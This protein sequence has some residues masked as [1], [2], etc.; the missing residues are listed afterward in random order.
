[1]ETWVDGPD[2]TRWEWWVSPPTSTRSRTSSSVPTPALAGVADRAEPVTTKVSPSRPRVARLA[3]GDRD[4]L[5]RRLLIGVAM[6]PILHDPA[7]VVLM[8]A[9]EVAR[10]TS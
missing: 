8:E 5:V 9:V 7:Q 1:M 3:V 4:G 6:G 2:G 10:V